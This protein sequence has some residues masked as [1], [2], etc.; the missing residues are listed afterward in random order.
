[1]NPRPKI[2]KYGVPFA[3]S[4]Y[5]DNRRR[6]ELH[7]TCGSVLLNVFDRQTQKRAYIGLNI[8]CNADVFEALTGKFTKVK[9]EDHKGKPRVKPLPQRLISQLQND[10]IVLYEKLNGLLAKA[11]ELNNF[12]TCKTIAEFKDEINHTLSYTYNE[13]YKMRIKELEKN[14]QWGTRDAA[15]AAYKALKR[16]K[17]SKIKSETVSVIGKPKMS[18][19]KVKSADVAKARTISFYEITADFLKDFHNYLEKIDNSSPN[20]I[21]NYM[22]EIKTIY[23]IALDSGLIKMSNY[24]F[25]RS[26]NPLKKRY[27][28][29][30]E[31]S[32]KDV[33]SKEDWEKLMAYSTPYPARQKALDM[34]K[35][36]YALHGANTNDM[37]KLLKSDLTETHV[38]FFR[39]KTKKTSQE[40]VKRNVKRDESID[41]LFI[42]YAAPAGSPYVLDLLNPTDKLGTESTHKRCKGINRNFNRSLEKICESIGIPRISMMK[43]RYQHSTDF[44]ENGGT[45]EQLNLIMGHKDI[46]T[47]KV[48]DKSLPN[49]KIEDLNE[50]LNKGLNIKND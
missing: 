9:A 21:A 41:F 15:T 33:L 8:Y 25:G 34:F 50:N 48:Y 45:L 4:Y 17:L 29:Q 42:K 16:F 28:V 23:R 30:R 1:M 6:L 32:N 20:T 26:N 35:L 39:K 11:Q 18:Y 43:A 5:F 19:S 37:C 27:Q 46:K 24:P 31:A 3:I 36:S 38:K 2:T 49:K 13:V 12:D 10:N 40:L 7:P 14:Q 22:T 47:T 44:R